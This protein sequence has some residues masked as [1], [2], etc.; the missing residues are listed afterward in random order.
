L[1]TMFDQHLIRPTYACI[2]HGGFND[3]NILIDSAGKT[4]AIDFERAGTGHIL[5]DIIALDTAIRLRLLAPEEA[6]LKERLHMEEALCSAQRFSDI[7][8]SVKGFLDSTNN[9][10]LIKAFS[11]AVHLRSLARRLI[12]GNPIDDIS[13]LYIALFYYA[14]NNLRFF[15]LSTLQREHALLS[16]SLLNEA[17]QGVFRRRYSELELESLQIKFRNRGHFRLLSIASHQ[18]KTPLGNIKAILENMIVGQYGSLSGKQ[19]QRLEQALDS[20][21]REFKMIERLLNLTRLESGKE[22]AELAPCNL[23]DCLRGALDDNRSGIERKGLTLLEDLPQEGIRITGDAILLTGAFSNVLENAIK[24]TEQG[25]VRVRC[26][27]DNDWAQVEIHDTGIGISQ[28]ILPFIFD[29]SFQANS[30][31]ARQF[32]G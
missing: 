5:R 4:W 3:D 22:K 25:E 15:S 30:G 20:V 2:T 17:I 23:V 11:T 26:W 19:Q 10:A 24:F 9:R 31:L 29:D 12:S 27:L 6:T 13:E 18:L 32:E 14:V 28:D 21:N 1:Q 16:A 7:E 8:D